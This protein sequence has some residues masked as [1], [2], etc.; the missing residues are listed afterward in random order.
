M[1]EGWTLKPLILFW[2]R[3]DTEGLERIE[4][5]SEPRGISVRGSVIT[6]E[7]GGLRLDHTWVL[8][9]DWRT[10]S[11]LVERWNAA[12]HKALRIERDG[13]GWRVDGVA[14]GDLDG[15]DEPDIS[16]TPFCNTLAIRRMA[17]GPDAS[18]VLDTVYVDAGE[19]TVSR[20]RQ[21][22]ERLGAQRLRYVDLGLSEG[23]E[24]EL[25]VDE[26]GLVVRYEHLFERVAP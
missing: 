7:D 21:R 4:I 23:F 2:R 13:P 6:L 5:V 25:S 26:Q 3:T 8:D 17:D 15:A 19:M 24:A 12:G 16:V 11:V 1:A 22:Y 10:Q 9:G 14:R 20:S 18:L